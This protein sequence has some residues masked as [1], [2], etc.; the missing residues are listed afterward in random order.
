M[1][2]TGVGLRPHPGSG[3]SENE[4]A[5]TCL[6]ENVERGATVDPLPRS[7]SATAT[8]RE[9]YKLTTRHQARPQPPQLPAP[10]GKITRE[11]V[12]KRSM[13]SDTAVNTVASTN[14]PAAKASASPEVCRSGDVSTSGGVSPAAG[15]ERPAPPA[16]E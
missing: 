6:A 14:H 11:L 3:D 1:A 8:T 15:G 10:A 13:T 9:R 12:H 7:P 16:T 5:V 2:D 4:T